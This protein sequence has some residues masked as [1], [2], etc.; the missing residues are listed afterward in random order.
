MFPVFTGGTMRGLTSSG[1]GNVTYSYSN[2]VLTITANANCFSSITCDVY[3][4]G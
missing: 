2:D 1:T 4:I 3:Y